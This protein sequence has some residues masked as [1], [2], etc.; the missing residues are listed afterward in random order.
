MINFIIL[1]SYDPKVILYQ[2][3]DWQIVAY[4]RLT[5]KLPP[6]MIDLYGWNGQC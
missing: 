2:A 3:S 1:K 5:I 4:K 6:D